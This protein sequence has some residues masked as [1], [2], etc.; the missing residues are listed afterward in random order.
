MKS[1]SLIIT[2]VIIGIVGY[3]IYKYVL[4]KKTITTATPVNKIITTSAPVNKIVVNNPTT[5]SGLLHS[6]PLTIM[7]AKQQITQQLLF[8]NKP[9]LRAPIHNIQAQQAYLNQMYKEEKIINQYEKASILARENNTYNQLQQAR[10]QQIANWLLY[11]K[12]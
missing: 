7:V 3:F 4:T 12:R 1:S 9:P 10:N 2:V 6:S 8:G 11:G 5:V